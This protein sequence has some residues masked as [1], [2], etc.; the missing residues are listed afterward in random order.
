MNICRV[1]EAKFFISA[2][3]VGACKVTGLAHDPKYDFTLSDNVLE[4]EDFRDPSQKITQVEKKAPP[5]ENTF[6]FK[7]G[8]FKLPQ[9]WILAKNQKWRPPPPSDKYSQYNLRFIDW[10]NEFNKIMEHDFE[11]NPGES[12][13]FGM[14]IQTF[15]SLIAEDDE[16]YIQE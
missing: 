12:P 15:D 14:D 13:I 5:L 8:G 1:C 2:N 11:A 3:K 16:R 9:A 7:Q 4:C 10:N 6:K